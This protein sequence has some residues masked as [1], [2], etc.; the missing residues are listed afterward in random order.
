MIHFISY[1]NKNFNNSKKRIFGQAIQSGWFNSVTIYN[2]KILDKDFVK[3]FKDILNCNRGGGFW[4]WKPYIIL[5]KLNEINENDILIYLDA[6]CVINPH[7]KKRFNDYI[8][9]LTQNNE[10]IISFQLPYIEDEWTIEEIFRY[11][12]INE[13]NMIR[14]TGQI[15]SGIIIIKKNEQSINLIKKWYNTI[16]DNPLLF[17]DNYNRFQKNNFKANRHDQSIFSILCKL[18]NV[19][20]IK[21]ETFFTNFG[22]QKSL[23]YP[24]WA[25]R[26]KI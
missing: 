26:Y 1:G 11:F 8:N 2:P 16:F 23:I 7:G 3:K 17:T 10:Y 19:Q 14:K 20:I 21:D 25:T 13:E 5:K 12:N 9:L 15:L 4:L 24:F 18:N 22:N 6:G